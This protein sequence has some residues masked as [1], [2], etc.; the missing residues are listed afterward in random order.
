MHHPRS[1][2]YRANAEACSHQASPLQNSDQKRRWQKLADQWMKM[3]EN[4]KN[5]RPRI[6]AIKYARSPN[7]RHLQYIFQD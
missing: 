1:Q 5:E 3:A 4:A 2:I 7:S 6:R